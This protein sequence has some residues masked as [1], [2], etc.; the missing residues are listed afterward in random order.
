VVDPP[1]RL[2]EVAQELAER[3]A[4]QPADQLATVKRALW[5]ALER[6]P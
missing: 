1:E 6:T 2:R 4:L 3:I 5:E